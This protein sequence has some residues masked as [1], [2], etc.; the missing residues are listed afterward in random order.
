MHMGTQQFRR[1]KNL[2]TYF[3]FCFSTFMEGANSMISMKLFIYVIIKV[4]VVCPTFTRANLFK[5]AFKL[6]ERGADL[7]AA[8]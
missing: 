4:L 2:V 6:Y 7:L 3:C 5:G 8:L 1:H